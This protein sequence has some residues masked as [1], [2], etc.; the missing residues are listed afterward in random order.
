VFARITGRAGDQHYKQHYGSGYGPAEDSVLAGEHPALGIVRFLD[1]VPIV[2]VNPF[3][4]A[5]E[6]HPGTRVLKQVRIRTLS[7][8]VRSA[9]VASSYEARLAE[10]GAQ[11]NENNHGNLVVGQLL[12]SRYHREHGYT[13][14]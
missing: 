12:L 9:D 5:A 13:N 1:K 10:E 3:S 14:H 8:N 7:K 4:V 6:K 11:W 2:R